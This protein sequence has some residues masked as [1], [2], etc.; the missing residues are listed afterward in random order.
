VA[1]QDAR[2][3]G[4]DIYLNRSSDF[5]KTWRTEGVRLNTGPSGEAEAR[6]PQLAIDG[7]GTIAVAWQEDRGDDQ[8]EGIYLTWSTDFGKAWLNADIRV[9]DPPSG[10]VAVKPQI[11]MLQDGAAVIA[12]EVSR[13]NRQE[14]AVKVLAPSIRQ[15][16]AR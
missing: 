6:L 4:W 16:S 12:W 11:A 3:G 15:T 1:W 8:Q 5:G 2:H 7:K 13:Q 9:D 10:G 14:I